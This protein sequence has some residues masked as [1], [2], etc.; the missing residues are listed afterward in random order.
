MLDKL[1][2][3]PHRFEESPPEFTKLLGQGAVTRKFEPG[4]VRA[5]QPDAGIPVE[6]ALSSGVSVFGMV[7]TGS[8]GGVDVVKAKGIWY[9]D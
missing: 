7:C 3:G 5:E 6:I 9:R 4:R 1:V 8:S 2:V